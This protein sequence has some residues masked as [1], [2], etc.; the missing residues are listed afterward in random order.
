[1][2]EPVTFEE[3]LAGL[4]AMVRL[5]LWFLRTWVAEHPAE[6]FAYVLEE[7]TD[8]ARWSGFKLPPKG[9]PRADDPAWRERVRLLKSL[10][11]RTRDEAESS[12]FEAGGLALS[13]DG[14]RA[15][16]RRAE[17]SG[18][19][20]V[21]NGRP[22]GSL[23]YEPPKPG[24]PRQARFHIANAVRPGSIFDAP[25]YL[26]ECLRRLMDRSEA[27]FGCDR[28][29]TATWLNEY[30]RWIALFPDAWRAHLG[31]PMT[32]PWRGLGFWG[33]FITA[34]GAFHAKRAAAF[35]ATGRLPY[36]PRASWCTFAALRAHLAAR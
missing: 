9:A 2:V 33:Q 13:L 1:M 15:E 25:E 32:G 3:Y 20:V 22:C 11:G 5:Q 21:P 18:F 34:R 30:P 31:P 24:A 12:R 10:H 36:R 26:P 23:G 17:A 29:S 19:A 16:A 35:R 27:A 28:L 6:P 8:I 7:R 14:I 4:C